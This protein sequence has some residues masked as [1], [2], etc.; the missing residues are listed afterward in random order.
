VQVLVERSAAVRVS[1]HAQQCNRGTPKR[2]LALL[3]QCVY[4]CA[5]EHVSSDL[6]AA[7]TPKAAAAAVAAATAAAAAAGE[8]GSGGSGSTPRHA[9]DS[10]GSGGNSTPRHTTDSHGS[11]GSA[12]GRHRTASDGGAGGHG[13]GAG[14]GNATASSG[15][16]KV[17][18]SEF[19]ELMDEVVSD[20]P[21]M[22]LSDLES[23][24]EMIAIE[25]LQV[26]CSASF[27]GEV[28][29]CEVSVGCI[30][31]RCGSSL[32]CHLLV[33][34]TPGSVDTCWRVH[35]WCQ[36]AWHCPADPTHESPATLTHARG[37][38]PTAATHMR[39]HTH[40]PC[41][42]WALAALARCTSAGGTAARSP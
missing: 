1:A 12:S 28:R 37:A 32:L 13:G 26:C 15:T 27:E 19:D 41:G 38:S 20:K 2:V 6:H 42:C 21:T 3:S 34:G 35:P 9:T 25:D 11:T 40:S 39:A 33:H 17:T 24:L 22:K 7:S 18:S 16:P 36:Q 8:S 30:A 4:I 10:H 5:Q 29:V 14:G 23:R 31:Q